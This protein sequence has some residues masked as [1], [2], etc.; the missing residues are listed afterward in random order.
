M[1]LDSTWDLSLQTWGYVCA[2]KFGRLSINDNSSIL[3]SGR[4]VPL[5]T[6]FLL[7]ALLHLPLLFVSSFYAGGY[8]RRS[9]DKKTPKILQMIAVLSSLFV[10]V[11]AINFIYLFTSLTP[12]DF[13]LIL[14]FVLIVK[15]LTWL[16]HTICIVQLVYSV[17]YHKDRPPTSCIVSWLLTLLVTL[18]HF[19]SLITYKVR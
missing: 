7:I 3:W 11:S 8:Q 10:L 2:G 17:R 4:D 15:L 1:V 16:V 12:E 5:C 9:K 19:I 6:Q 18:F 14:L 13:S